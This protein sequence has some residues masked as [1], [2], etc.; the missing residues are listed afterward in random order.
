MNITQEGN[1]NGKAGARE[2]NMLR[3]LTYL[4]GK[5]LFVSRSSLT[6]FLAAELLKVTINRKILWPPIKHGAVR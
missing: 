1:C 6:Y 5:S 4:A 3:E 2:L